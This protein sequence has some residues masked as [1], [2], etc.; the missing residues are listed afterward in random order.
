[1]RDA[2]KS[3]LA[4]VGSLTEVTRQR[5]TAVAR[6]LVQQG[7]ATAEQVGSLVDDLLAQSRQN[8]EAVSAL[9]TFEVDRTLGRLGL[10]SND[11]VS[12]LLR[13]V[14][15]LEDEVRRLSAT[16]D[17]RTTGSTAAEPGP[18]TKR[19]AAKTAAKKAPAS[20]TAGAARAT[21]PRKAPAKVERQGTAQTAERK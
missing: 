1:M 20:G 17:G 10:A 2:V 8:R 9:V 12:D 4:L 7:E 14:R 6:M 16:A 5:A 13:R 11:E 15:S 21:K 18:G 19:A 3:Y